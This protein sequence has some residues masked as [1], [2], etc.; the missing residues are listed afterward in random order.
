MAVH[1]PITEGDLVFTF[2]TEWTLVLKWDDTAA[3]KN[4]L[5]KQITG[6]KAV[7]FVGIHGG[8]IFLIEVKDYRGSEHTP[9]T[10]NTLR[11]GGDDLVTT[12]A[13]KVRDTIAGLVGAARLDRTQD[14]T[15]LAK[16]L[17]DPKPEL[18]VAL[19]IEHAATLPNVKPGVQALRNKAR[20]GV[21]F[22]RLQAAVRWLGA[23][24]MI[25]S[26]ADAHRL[27]G[28]DVRSKHGATRRTSPRP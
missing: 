9:V 7:D 2:D 24:A 1:D 13:T 3:F 19:W 8:T 12:V 10:R 27:P 26:R 11:D 20:G 14:A 23:R 25:C 15:L 6:S 22:D 28:L 18:C 5:C 4:G 16:A 21:E 17:V